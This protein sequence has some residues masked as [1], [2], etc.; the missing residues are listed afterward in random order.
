[1]FSEIT[2][3]IKEQV[4]F[5]SSYA[6]GCDDWVEIKKQILLGI[7]PNLRTHFSTRHPKTKEQRLNN[8]EK[9][10]IHYWKDKTGT[11]LKLRTL[12]ERRELF[13]VL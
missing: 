3:K 13:G 1:M 4:D 12:A 5:V 8:F 11:E 2:L 9:R 6:S 7:S 10:I